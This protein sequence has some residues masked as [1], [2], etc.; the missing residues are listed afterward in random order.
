MWKDPVL[1]GLGASL[2]ASA[3]YLV[4]LGAP[5]AGI[6]VHVLT[7]VVNALACFAMGAFAPG[8]FWGTGVLGGFS[9]LSAVSLAAAQSTPAGAAATLGVSLVT[10]L[11]A[12]FAGD[13]ARSAARGR[14]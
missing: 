12:W 1:V 9:T 2:G 11:G 4:F 8:R 3:R 10:C 13:A 6:E 7:A 5:L 14:A